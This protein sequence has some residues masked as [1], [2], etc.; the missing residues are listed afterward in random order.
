MNFGLPE[1]LIIAFIVVLL[2]GAKRLPLLAKGL[3]SSL[4]SFKKGLQDG[5][6]DA[7]ND[8]KMN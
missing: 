5:E 3:G 1:I 4:K 8:D 6:H 2:F 7:K